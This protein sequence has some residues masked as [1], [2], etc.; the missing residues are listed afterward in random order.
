MGVVDI[1]QVQP[2]DIQS[3]P[4]A[5]STASASSSQGNW[6]AQNAP[7]P[8]LDKEVK[9]SSRHWGQT[10]EPPPFH[11]LPKDTK[12]L[13]AP[14]LPAEGIVFTAAATALDK[15]DKS[16]G[17]TGQADPK[18]FK[19]VKPG[20]PILGGP[21]TPMPGEAPRGSFV[22]TAPPAPRPRGGDGIGYGRIGKP[23]PITESVKPTKAP[24]LA[25]SNEALTQLLKV[26][27]QGPKRDALAAEAKKRGLPVPELPTRE[28]E[29]SQALGETAR[30]DQQFD[31][32][33]KKLA[34]KKASKNPSKERKTAKPPF[35]PETGV[36]ENVARRQ[37]ARERI[38]GKP[39]EQ[40]TNTDILAA[41]KLIDEGYTGA[42]GSTVPDKK[43]TPAKASGPTPEQIDAER[44]KIIGKPKFQWTKSDIEAADQLRAEGQ[45]GSTRPEPTANKNADAFLKKNQP[46]KRKTVENADQGKLIVSP[47]AQT[48]A[49]VNPAPVEPAKA[50]IVETPVEAKIADTPKG[51]DP[52]TPPA[53]K[54]GI[55]WG[56]KG[57]A[58]VARGYK[59]PFRY[60]VVDE[61]DLI[62]SHDPDT[63]QENPVFDQTIQPRDRTRAGYEDQINTMVGTLDPEELG[64]S[65]KASDGA[66]FAADDAMVESGNGRTIALKRVYK[67]H[68]EKAEEYSGHVSDTAED[69]GFDKDK[70]KD[71]PKPVRVRIRTG[72]PD[73]VT[74]QDF[75]RDANE[76]S[77]A[78]MGAV[79]TA[80]SDQKALTPEVMAL[81]DPSESGD[82]N[83][84]GNRAFV[85]KFAQ[86]VVSPGQKNPFQLADGS[87]SSEGVRRIRNAV[88]SKAYGGSTA[89]EKLAEDPNDNTK[90]I[91][92]GLV[93]AAPK[94]ADMQAGID[95]GDLYDL[96]PAQAIGRAVARLT[97]L[98][99]Q[100]QTI[101]DFL[102]QEDLY[103]KDPVEGK[104]LDIFDRH[105]R[106]SKSIASVF[107]NYVDLVEAVGSPKQQGFFTQEPPTLFELLQ[108]ADDMIKPDV[109]SQETTNPGPLLE[110]PP[111]S[112]GETQRVAGEETSQ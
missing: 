86:Q 24:P 21:V 31:A 8:R 18:V 57:N 41:D 63:L 108:A 59:V 97:H 99:E 61:S 60:A 90:T 30:I 73:G 91:T 40:W 32:A 58:K 2:D 84:A 53:F 6:F 3:A 80:N 94:F 13:G 7:K 65:Y 89:L 17:F 78:T 70:L 46:K 92:N 14:I 95:R 23:A 96:N 101:Q 12:I 111:G 77:K 38:I 68:P 76:D 4:P 37:D 109:K 15:L 102:N 55:V 103:G 93:I 25:V 42:G 50:P 34:E 62:T 83:T 47:S 49:D 82:I 48:K 29:V 16:L 64:H 104:I 45:I 28:Q 36:P 10:K 20:T 85:Q 26:E 9:Q 54:K 39:R 67:S 87:V 51:E 107:K 75:A 74:R 52:P 11:K 72:L 44:L 98:R 88:F 81:F 79:E 22:E 66:P 100:K 105:R 5:A 35:I 71:I 56:K 110:E 33:E 27:A 106:S 69:F 1:S 19:G 43:A 112:S